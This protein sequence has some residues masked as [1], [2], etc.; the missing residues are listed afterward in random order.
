MPLRPALPLQPIHSLKKGV[1]EKKR[2]EL[3]KRKERII[4]FEKT[5]LFSFYIK[6]R[7]MSLR[8]LP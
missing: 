6:T 5:S 7:E 1:R 4:F 8:S 3:E 2:K